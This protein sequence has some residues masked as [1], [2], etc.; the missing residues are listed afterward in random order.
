VDRAALMDHGR[1][2][3]TGTPQD[4]AAAFVAQGAPFDRRERPADRNAPEYLVRI[5]NATV[6]RDGRDV[7]EDVSLDIRPGEHWAVLGENGAGKTTLLMLIMAGI[8]PLSG[9]RVDWFGRGGPADVFE[10]RRRIGLVSPEMQADYAYDVDA[11]EFVLSGFDSSI[12]LYREPEEHETRRALDLIGLAG[13]DG[14]QRSRI[15]SLSYGQLRRLLVARA[16]VADPDLL[17]LDEAA[18]G[19]DPSARNGLLRTLEN[20]AAAG[21]SLVYATHRQSDLPRCINRILT[22]HNRRAK[23]RE[24]PSA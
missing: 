1:I 3:R 9:G 4:V 21:T 6:R 8:R 12:G 5:R 7:L 2:V 19:L 20:A 13:L 16:L 22:I 15:R 23:V 17:L 10:I 24:V 18:V 11:L 14:L